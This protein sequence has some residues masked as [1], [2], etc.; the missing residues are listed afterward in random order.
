ML[1]CR[2]TIALALC[3]LAAIALS[4]SATPA[5]GSV[6]LGQLPSGPTTSCDEGYDW[7][8]DPFAPTYVVPG[9]GTI[10][11][12]SHL[13]APGAGQ[14]IKLKIWHA[15][16]SP[17]SG[18]HFL[19]VGHDGPRTLTEG[20][21]NTFPASI[22]VNRGDILG[23]RT[24]SAGVGCLFAAAG[25]L[26]Y[27]AAGDVADGELA[28]PFQSPACTWCPPPVLDHLLNVTAVFEPSNDFSVQI[29]RNARQGTAS[30]TL[31]APNPGQVAMSG[32]GLVSAAAAIYPA[33]ASL[34]GP[35]PPPLAPA[36]LL[37]KARGKKKGK[38]N[39]TGKVK[40]NV[41]ITYTPTG[42]DAATQSVKVKLKKKR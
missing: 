25:R 42:G 34:G 6:A 11:S 16:L 9:N 18:F 32:R 38:L 4:S 12:W 30:L 1:T 40:L 23:L 20:A 26:V 8:Q 27:K 15:S 19:A 21:L 29:A 35:E 24:G 28:A 3:A 36:Q 2:R 14:T 10:T 37:I 39:E 5:A 31:K 22:P 33:P 17:H 41:A 13:A 7:V